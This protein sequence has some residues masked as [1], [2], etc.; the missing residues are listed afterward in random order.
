MRSEI[1]N[2]SMV[3]NQPLRDNSASSDEKVRVQ[4][5]EGKPAIE[6]PACGYMH[7]FDS[8]WKW[9]G[10]L[11]APTFYPSMALRGGGGSICHFFVTDGKIQFQGDCTHAFKDKTLDLPEIEA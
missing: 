9:N 6:C 4:M 10:S 2:G 11:T 3:Y 5:Y 1:V 8:R 7:L